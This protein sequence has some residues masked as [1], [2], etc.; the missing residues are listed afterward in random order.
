MTKYMHKHYSIKSELM[1]I[2]TVYMTYGYKYIK[3]QIHFASKS[4][5]ST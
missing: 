4:K 2:R 1:K 3:S 5:T